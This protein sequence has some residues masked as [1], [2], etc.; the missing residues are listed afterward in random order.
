MCKVT[1]FLLVIPLVLKLLSN[2]EI[3]LLYVDSEIVI[4]IERGVCSGLQQAVALVE[5]PVKQEIVD[6]CFPFAP[7]DSGC[8]AENNKHQ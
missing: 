5:N 6:I 3:P 7:Q 4:Y 2:F 8:R 1:K